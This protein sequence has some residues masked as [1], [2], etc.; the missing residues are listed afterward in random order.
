MRRFPAHMLLCLAFALSAWAGGPEYVAGVSFFDPAVKGMPLTWA[1]G[2]VTY[3]SDQGNLSGIMPQSS[4]DA[5]VATAFSQWTS[6]PTA[7]VA[8]VH[9][10]QLA[11]DVSGANVR[12]ISGT[13]TL[14]PDILP[15]ATATPV[16]IVYDADGSVTDALLGAGASSAAY[17]ANDGAFG[18]IDNF[19]S[20]AQLLHAL[21]VLN[22]NCAA[23]AAQLPICNTISSERSA[24][25]W[26]S[27]GRR[28]I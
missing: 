6:I 22:G 28:P 19:S 27:T 15:S 24:G 4:A 23:N 10:G 3:F 11:E 1:N 13:L 9:A 8:S 17:C 7:A 12:L 16:A 2:T 25:C 18:G 20:S 14:P 26:G 5:F 21:I